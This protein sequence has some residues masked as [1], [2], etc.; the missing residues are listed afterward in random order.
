MPESTPQALADLLGSNELRIRT[1]ILEVPIE[2]LGNENDLAVT[3][4]I[5]FLD[6]CVW[7]VNRT[8]VNRSHLALTWQGITE[9]LVSVLSDMSLP[10]YCVWVAG[11]DVLLSAV[12]FDD[13]KQFW[14]FIRS[15]FRQSRG[16]LLSVPRQ[17]A[18]LL[19]EEERKLWIEYGRLAVWNNR[20]REAYR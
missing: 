20:A 1:G 9:D 3:L 13:R 6:F 5:G 19:P 2:L 12:S 18:H 14:A 4:S 10:G 11:L 17:A 8:P 15:T 7:K 16:L